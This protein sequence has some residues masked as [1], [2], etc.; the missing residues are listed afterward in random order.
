MFSVKKV[1]LAMMLS[2]TMSAGAQDHSFPIP[3]GARK[4]ASLGGATTL[5]TGKNYTVVVYD[6]ESPIAAVKEFY[7]T[8]LPGA[9]QTNDGEDVR[10]SASEGMIKLAR[11]G[12]GTRITVT[13]G[14]R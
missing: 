5:A 14:P 13:L 9:V 10:F 2:M 7:A 3:A 11:L 8:R 12:A 4:N 6:H 1:A